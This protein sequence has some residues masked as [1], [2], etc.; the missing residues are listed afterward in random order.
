[1]KLTAYQLCEL[2][3]RR[4][5]EIVQLY[6][7]R[8][9]TITLRY[10]CNYY[11][12]KI[13]LVK[14]L[15]WMLLASAI[16]QTFLYSSFQ[17]FYFSNKWTFFWNRIFFC[18]SPLIKTLQIFQSV[19]LLFNSPVITHV[20]SQEY[21]S[22]MHFITSIWFLNSAVG[23][24]KKKKKRNIPIYTNTYYRTEMKLIPIII[25]II[26]YFNLIL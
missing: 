17:M 20:Y 9:S 19:R 4:I 13:W 11:L 3:N 25:W 2:Y 8:L 15:F 6:M 14:D 16:H 23:Q 1:M 12:W 10:Y 22:D 7:C 21:L 24:K 5:I 18:S 26:A